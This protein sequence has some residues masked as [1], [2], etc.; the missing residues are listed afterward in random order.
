MSMSWG[1]GKCSVRSKVLFG[2]VY[3]LIVTHAL[4]EIPHLSWQTYPTGGA[5][6]AGATL[7]AEA[8]LERLDR[9]VTLRLLRDGVPVWI[10]ENVDT[11]SVPFTYTL[12]SPDNSGSYWLEAENSDGKV[13]TAPKP[14]AVLPRTAPLIFWLSPSGA[15]RGDTLSASVSEAELQWLDNGVPIPGATF[16]Q[17]TIP[18]NGQGPYQLRATDVQGTHLSASI[19][20]SDTS[21]PKE[22]PFFW[23]HPRT[24]ELRE[25]DPYDVRF[26]YSIYR[27]NDDQNTEVKEFWN[28]TLQSKPY[29]D[30]TVPA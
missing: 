26:E 21:L 17:Y 19:R 20:V 28:D 15:K 23:T 6:S 7:S 3:L 16:S 5:V 9:P 10:R 30:P 27:G 13:Q 2:A 4:A 29:I 12:T 25:G 11:A 14:F 24:H 8:R 18:M 1:W 22:A